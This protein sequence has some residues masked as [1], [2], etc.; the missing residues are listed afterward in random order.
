MVGP[1]VDSGALIVGGLIGTFL[2]KYIVPYR[3]RKP[4]NLTFGIITIGIGVTLVV[5]VV[6]MPVVVISLL[7][8]TYLGEI[9]FIEKITE[10]VTGKVM[11]L[12]SKKRS[13]GQEQTFISSFITIVIAICF[14]SMGL[15]G[16]ITEGITGD[17]GMLITKAALDFF[18]GIVFAASMGV[19]ICGIAVPQFLIL[20]GLYYSAQ[21]FMPYVTP[22]MLNDFSAAGGVIFVATGLRMCDIKIFPII[23]MLPTLIIVMPLSWLWAVYVL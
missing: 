4:L 12:M 9:M 14:G 21:Y 22:A 16:A 1:V 23:N 6:Y 20:S 18:C 8:G 19:V 3:I 5:K 11:K 2:G 15:F 7:V 17:P 10:K 13:G